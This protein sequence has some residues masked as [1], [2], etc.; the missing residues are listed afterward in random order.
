M[1]SWIAFL[2]DDAKAHPDWVSTILTTIQKNDFDAFGGPYYAWHPYG[3]APS[4]LPEDFGTYESPQGYGLLQGD[5]FIPGGNCVL[6]SD[7]ARRIGTFSIELGMNGSLCGYGEETQFFERMRTAGYRMGYVPQLKI[8][9]CVLPYKYTL[10]WQLHSAFISGRYF[11]RFQ[12]S[13]GKNVSSIRQITELIKY[14][15]KNIKNF[16]IHKPSIALFIY[17]K[18]IIHRIGCII[19]SLSSKG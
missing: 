5:T 19:E 15:I 8:D 9:H 14:S 10:R 4:W 2:D 3:P 16:F 18:C 11:I 12:H 7:V 6:R 17:T 13:L 1:T